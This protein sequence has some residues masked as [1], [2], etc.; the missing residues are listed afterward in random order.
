MELSKQEMDSNDSV[1]IVQLKQ[2]FGASLV[3]MTG[4]SPAVLSLVYVYLFFHM[5]K[6]IIFIR[7]SLII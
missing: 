4:I 2:L 6:L 7:Y 5:D 3:F 1:E